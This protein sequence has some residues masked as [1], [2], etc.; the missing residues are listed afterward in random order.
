MTFPFQFLHL[1]YANWEQASFLSGANSGNE[2]GA[3]ESK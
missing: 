3:T 1:V 2:G